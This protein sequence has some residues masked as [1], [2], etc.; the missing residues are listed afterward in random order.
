MRAEAKARVLGV[1]LDDVIPDPRDVILVGLMH[2][3]DGFKLLLSGEDYAE[4]LERIED[5][6][7]MDLVGRTVSNAVKLSTVKPKTRRVLRTKPIPKLRIVDVLRVR[8]FRKGNISKAMCGV[9]ETYGSVVNVPFRMGG[10]PVVAL[11]GPEA[12][13][14]VNRHG[15]FYLRSKDYIQDFERE[16]GASR[17][18]PGMDGAEHHN[19][20][21]MT[22]NG[23]MSAKFRL[24][25]P[26][27]VVSEVRKTGHTL[28][29]M[30]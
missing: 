11:M 22:R 16:F 29:S 24:R 19:M 4:K 21:P 17:T 3:C 8:D 1:I 20:L 25:K 27:A 7:R 26:I 6:S 9:Y 12:N 18:L 28:T 14:W 2:T 13:H 15:R 30:E 5:V 10:Q 23:G